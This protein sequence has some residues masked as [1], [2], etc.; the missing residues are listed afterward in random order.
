M[1]KKW[2]G[3]KGDA[4]RS[5]FDHKKYSENFEKIFNKKSQVIDSK[6]KEK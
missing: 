3:G 4:P 6:Q 5:G 1:S 2:H